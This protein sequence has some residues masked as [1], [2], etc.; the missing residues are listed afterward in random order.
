MA[1]YEVVASLCCLAVRS[2]VNITCQYVSSKTDVSTLQYEARR[3]KAENSRTT[4][5]FHSTETKQMI[6][7]D[8]SVRTERHKHRK[9]IAMMMMIIIIIIM[10]AT[11]KRKGKEKRRD[12]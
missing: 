10:G 2:I 3:Q 6:K 9:E 12:L 1:R 7:R 8:Q 4:A 11:V 5:D